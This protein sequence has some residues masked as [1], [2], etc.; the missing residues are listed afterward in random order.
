MARYDEELGRLK[1]GGRS[2]S[3]WWREIAKIRDDVGGNEGG[4]FADRVFRKIGDGST[5]LF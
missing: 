5:I 1:V 4:W 3:N 2:V